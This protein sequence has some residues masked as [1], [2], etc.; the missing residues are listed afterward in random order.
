[1]KESV[2]VPN[3]TVLANG[4]RLDDGRLIDLSKLNWGYDVMFDINTGEIDADSK[5]LVN[6]NML[7]KAGRLTEVHC[8]QEEHCYIGEVHQGLNE[9][10]YAELVERIQMDFRSK[11]YKVS[12]RALDYVLHGYMSGF[13]SAYRDEENGVHLFVT[14][15]ENPLNVVLTTLHEKCK[16]WQT[17]YFA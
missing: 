12:T 3:D 15:W 16:D 2:F 9:E 1:M 10:E 13:K 4:Y 7:K 6:L 8:Y 11:G 5:N 14:C 17:T